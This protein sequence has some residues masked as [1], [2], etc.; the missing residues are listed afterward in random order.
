[1]SY[2]R[3]VTVATICGHLLLQGLIANQTLAYF[4]C[5]IYLFLL[6]I[7]IDKTK[8]RFRQHMSNEMAHYACDCW[9]AEMKTTYVRDT[10]CVLC[11]LG[12]ALGL[13]IYIYIYHIV[14]GDLYVT[15]LNKSGRMSV[16]H[17]FR[18]CRFCEKI[19]HSSILR[20][21]LKMIL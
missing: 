11:S 10:P 20:F 12:L 6:K 13:Y 14:S 3:D 2:F 19:G 7:G 15:H 4:M 16:N 5:R 9:D 21:S 1:M 8:F 18:K 17:I